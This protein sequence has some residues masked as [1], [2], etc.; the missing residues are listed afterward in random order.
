MKILIVNTLYKPYVLGGAEKICEYM[1]YSLKDLGHDVSILTTHKKNLYEEKEFLDGIKIIRLPIKNVYWHYYKR[2]PNPLKRFLWHFIDIYNPW[3][4]KNL[5]EVLEN[6]KYDII[7]SH[8][9]SGFS[10]CIWGVA[11]KL[12]I[13]VIQVLHDLYSICPNSNMFNGLKSCD[14]RCLKCSLF[15]FFH[16]FFSKDVDAVVGVSEYVLKKHLEYGLFKNALIKTYIR[17]VLKVDFLPK[18]KLGKNKKEITFGYIGTLNKAKGVELLLDVFSKINIKNNILI[19]GKG[20]EK[21]ES[22]MKDKYSK[23]NILF[24]G[25]QKSEE[26][27]N[28]IDCLIVPSLCNDTFPTVILESFI[29]CIPVIASNMGGIPEIVNKYNGYIFNPDKKSELRDIILELV[30]NPY[31]LYQKRKKIMETRE[32]YADLKYWRNKYLEI[33]YKLKKS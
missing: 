23:E 9:I 30:N 11:K 8:N 22:Y 3:M 14:N 29:N 25:Y 21:Y 33:I 10:S 16:P 12:N 20:Y 24:L 1:A 17:N 6:D 31:S 19:A 15:R 28:K 13:P 18:V 5:T 4:K 2:K 27:F 7:I 26:F 32:E